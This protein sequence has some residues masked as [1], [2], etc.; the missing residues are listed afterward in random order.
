MVFLP[1]MGWWKNPNHGYFYNQHSHR[2]VLI[3]LH[4]CCLSLSFIRD[5][6]SSMK[7]KA[8]KLVLATCRRLIFK[9]KGQ[10]TSRTAL[11]RDS[12][13]SRIKLFGAKKSFLWGQWH[14]C[15]GLLVMSPL[16]FKGRLVGLILAWWRHTCYM[17]PEIH[18]WCDTRPLGSQHGN[19]SLSPHACFSRGRMLDSIRRPPA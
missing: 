16:G 10:V 8:I 1:T 12:I 5:N 3:S 7:W 6:K 19:Q 17:F 13:Q 2:L 4:T 9:S 15:F 11:P 14:P 18:L